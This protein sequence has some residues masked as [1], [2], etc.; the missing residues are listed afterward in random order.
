MNNSV[1]T[2]R[3][4]SPSM[5]LNLPPSNGIQRNIEPMTPRSKEEN[6]KLLAAL[7]PLSPLFELVSGNNNNSPFS[8]NSKSS[9]IED[10][11]DSLLKESMNNSSI[12]DEGINFNLIFV[13]YNE[14]FRN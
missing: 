11:F 2:P 12:L 3:T 4:R 10:Y 1:S 7:S 9:D 14:K 13:I 6:K 5:T 8:P